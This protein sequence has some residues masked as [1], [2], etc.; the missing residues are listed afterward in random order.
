M[1][2]NES[3]KNMLNM[4]TRKNTNKIC[5]HRFGLVSSFAGAFHARFWPFPIYPTFFCHLV[6]CSATYQVTKLFIV[7]CTFTEEN[8]SAKW[9]FI[10]RSLA[11]QFGLS[12][13]CPM[14]FDG[15]EYTF[16]DFTPFQWNQLCSPFFQWQVATESC[17]K[18]DSGEVSQ[19]IE[20]WDTQNFPVRTWYHMWTSALLVWFQSNCCMQPKGRL[21]FHVMPCHRQHPSEKTFSHVWLLGT[22]DENYIL[23]VFS[24]MFC[25]CFCFGPH[26]RVVVAVIAWCAMVFWLRELL[27][28]ESQ[29]VGSFFQAHVMV[30]ISRFWMVVEKTV[31]PMGRSTWSVI[32]L[33]AAS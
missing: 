28:G 32:Y 8:A 27:V 31:W 22:H 26:S 3:S 7:R 30:F 16:S 24:L 14:I 20:T 33:C 11:C 10:L 23:Y 21:P 5:H 13:V 29:K 6:W 19:V 2:W 9:N 15:A 18:Y 17:R 4:R 12:E 1:T 25:Q